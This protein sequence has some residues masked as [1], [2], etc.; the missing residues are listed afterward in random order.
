MLCFIARPKIDWQ[1]KSWGIFSLPLDLVSACAF[2]WAEKNDFHI[3]SPSHTIQRE[4]QRVCSRYK[5]REAMLLHSR[6]ISACCQCWEWPLFILPEFRFNGA[7]FSWPTATLKNGYPLISSCCQWWELIVVYFALVPFQLCTFRWD[8]YITTEGLTSGRE[9]ASRR[10]P[11][12]PA[13]LFA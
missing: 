2:A 1:E 5:L 9:V 10:R 8:N 11:R 13:A 6:D 12:A 4:V 3:V 7:H